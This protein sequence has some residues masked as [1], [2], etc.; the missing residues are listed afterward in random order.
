VAEAGFPGFESSAWIGIVAPAKTPGPVVDRL[1]RE[2]NAIIR[3]QDV[4]EKMLRIYFQ[5]V[6]TAPE[7]LANLMRAETNRWAKVIKASG[8][9]AD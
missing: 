7:G 9:K 3:S 8:A 2:L 6:G 1:S 4:R 5:P